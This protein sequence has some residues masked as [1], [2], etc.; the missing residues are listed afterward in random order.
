M[1]LGDLV[2]FFGDLALL[3]APDQLGILGRKLVVDLFALAANVGCADGGF[4][5][6]SGRQTKR[7]DATPSDNDSRPSLELA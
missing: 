5:D 1:C 2:G 3:L 7:R 4:G 6:Y